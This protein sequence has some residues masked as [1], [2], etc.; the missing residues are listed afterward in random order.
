MKIIRRKHPKVV[1]PKV[2][3]RGAYHPQFNYWSDDDLKP[4]RSTDGSAGY[5]LRADIPEGEEIVINPGESYVFSTG[6]TL[7]PITRNWT[8]YVYSRSGISTNKKVMLLNGVAVIDPDYRGVIHAPLIN[9]GKEP[10]RIHR[11]D[12]IAQ[13]CF[14]PFG[15]PSLQKVPTCM[16]STT[17]RGKGKFGHTGVQ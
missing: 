3:L 10:M 7:E 5:D 2:V 17:G 9:F 16:M 15:I 14:F 6:V 12:R 1:H 11:G 13:I 8:A 4:T